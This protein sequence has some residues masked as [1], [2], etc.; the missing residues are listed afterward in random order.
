MIGR[1]LA[2]SGVGVTR[3]TA[4]LHRHP[5][6]FN[7]SDSG[8][9]SLR[10]VRGPN[11]SGPLGWVGGLTEG[12][13]GESFP[14]P[15]MNTQPPNPPGS[16]DVPPPQAELEAARAALAPDYDVLQ[17]LGRGG[18]AVVY[19]AREV[20]LDREV[21]I[22]VLPAALAAD[23]EFVERFQREARTAG[24][25]EHP[26]I[27]PIYRVGR[28]GPDGR[29]VFFVMKMLRGQSLSAVLR[30]RGRLAVDEIRRIMK[31]TAAALGFA[32]KKG[33]VHRDIKPDNILLDD[34]GRCVVTDFGIAKTQSGPHTA[35]GTSMGTPRYMSPEHAQGTPVD[36][37]SDIYSLGVV[38]YQCLTGHTPF[39]ADN[40]F[41]ILYKHINETLPRPTLTTPDEW[42]IYSVIEKCLGK[43][44]E[45]RFQ[46]TDELL[47]ALGAE[48]TGQNTLTAAVIDRRISAMVPTEVI[49]SSV[50]VPLVERVRQHPWYLSTEA[51]MTRMG[52]KM[53]HAGIAASVIGA[54]LIFSLASAVSGPD[55]GVGADSVRLVGQTT[56]A[57]TT[58]AQTAGAQTPGALTP[59]AQTPGALTAGAAG[60]TTGVAARLDTISTKVGGTTSTK[61]V[62]AAPGPARPR[63]VRDVRSNC[64]A[65]GSRA[66]R[67][68][69]T[70]PVLL[71][72]SI[73]DKVQ[74]D[75]LRVG[76]D[77]CGF[78]ATQ[79]FQTI[80]TLR[81][82]RQ[83]RP[84]GRQE[85]IVQTIP[86]AAIG[87]RH[88]RVRTFLLNISDGTY[89]AE[90]LIIDAA[91][92]QFQVK[93]EFE[94]T[95]KKK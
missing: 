53:S 9:I 76:Y 63:P 73:P 66:L 3:A 39:D 28:A 75:T 12:A 61:S 49:T 26:N 7:P 2:I 72:D 43:K 86:D 79:P 31:E 81:K 11:D 1:R 82:I 50:P 85:P 35:A 18:M 57:Q 20:A 52:L 92:R 46:T 4:R 44:P 42:G 14:L 95:E 16:P 78:S 74:G 22:K 84:L 56:G 27:V 8:P 45:Q 88:R 24:Q 30:G 21:A 70:T 59:G 60:T 38:A 40:P 69:M 15:P 93:R 34:E 23:N 5:K 29:M 54:L 32:A 89:S 51:R 80:V 48:V 67:T 62:A 10:Q 68:M 64:P 65:V 37:R 47:Q 25:L 55:G 6:G 71:V 90:V 87:P 94:L 58:G 33:V 91:Q 41:A 83:R 77:L 36:V 13:Q 17:E 19:R